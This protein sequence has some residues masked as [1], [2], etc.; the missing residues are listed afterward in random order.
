MKTNMTTTNQ[1]QYQLLIPTNRMLS[2]TKRVAVCLVWIVAAVASTT[3]A[4]SE[5]NDLHH[6]A[7]RQ[8]FYKI[9]R[10]RPNGYWGYFSSKKASHKMMKSHKMIPSHKM[11]HRRHRPKKG[12]SMK[13]S[14]KEKGYHYYYYYYYYN[15]SNK[16]TRMKHKRRMGKGKGGGFF[17]FPRP[18]PPTS[19]PRPTTAMPDDATP[20]MSPTTPMPAP[21]TACVPTVNQ[22]VD[23]EAD[24][25]LQLASAGQ[26]VVA[27]CDGTLINIETGDLEVTRADNPLQLCCEGMLCGLQLSND[28]NVQ[29]TTAG[30][31]TIAGVDVQ[32][33]GQNFGSQLS[34]T[35]VSTDP[36]NQLY[37]GTV[38]LENSN[39]RNPDTSNGGSSNVLIESTGNVMVMGSLFQGSA[40]SGLEI[41][42]A[43]AVVV[44]DSQFL[45]NGFYGLYTEWT[46]PFGPQDW[47]NTGQDVTILDSQFDD[48]QSAGYLAS[49]LGRLPSI[50][51]L[52]S[53]FSNHPNDVVSLCCSTEYET[54]VFRGNTGSGNTGGFSG[55]QGLFAF[56]A[57][58]D[59]CAPLGEDF[60][61]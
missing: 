13:M 45:S 31:V 59:I 5:P 1:Y 12:S 56:R 41:R 53:D 19:T 36:D 6:D 25:R 7:E 29:V 61:L 16:G 57:P 58:N 55:C 35:T 15:D 50:A 60:E 26:D 52:N 27:I 49:N 3:A 37:R 8:L 47:E 51:I 28:A 43:T 38:V 48:N 30:D 10:H 9:R 4:T 14:Y 54:L 34:I 23:N 44:S 42:E 17:F 18:S 39:F 21:S 40:S 2:L 33:G 11:Y 20:T 24:L 22:C 32:G 46:A